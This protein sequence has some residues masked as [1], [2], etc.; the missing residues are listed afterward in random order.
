MGKRE[1]EKDWE[2]ESRWMKGEGG[3]EGEGRSEIPETMEGME[4][5]ERE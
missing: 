2:R 1:R 5:R 3:M 4:E